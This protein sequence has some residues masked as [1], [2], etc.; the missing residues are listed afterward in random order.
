MQN[1][2]KL[3][4][5]SA[6]HREK[7]NKTKSYAKA[8]Q[9]QETTNSHDSNETEN[10]TQKNPKFKE[11][12]AVWAPSS[13]SCH[14]AMRS[15]RLTSRTSYHQDSDAMAPGLLSCPSQIGI[16]FLPELILDRR[17]RSLARPPLHVSLL[18]RLSRPPPP[19]RYWLL[20]KRRNLLIQ[21]RLSILLNLVFHSLVVL[22]VV[23]IIVWRKPVAQ[24]LAATFTQAVGIVCRRSIRHTECGADISEAEF[25]R[26]A[27]DVLVAVF[28]AVLEHEVARWDCGA[29][30]CVVGLE[31]EFGKERGYDAAVDE[32]TGFAVAVLVCVFF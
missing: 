19:N 4:Q 18:G 27:L 30:E 32:C 9:S 16:R 22:V 6:N 3:R 1:K 12:I 31:E 5:K 24:I 7:R 28:Q 26:E 2:R 29:F 13:P 23:A 14:L 21:D 15:T 17:F 8:S 10:D 20:R 11:N 25:V